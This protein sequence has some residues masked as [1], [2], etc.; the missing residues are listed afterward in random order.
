MKRLLLPVVL[1]FILLAVPSA[2]RADYYFLVD[3]NGANEAPPNNETGTGAAVVI[4]NDALTKI[5][6]RASFSG[7]TGPAIAA[8]FHVGDVGVAGPV[9]LPF[10]NFP[11][12]DSDP[13]YKITL[14]A[15]DFQPGGGL[16]TFDDAI[17]AF[18]AGRMYMNIH[19]AAHPGGEIRGQVYYYGP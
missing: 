9:V 10:S 2:A 14:K 19:T 3:L 12:V 4:I 6:V 11:A 16:Q 1:A 5:K 8:H 13:K 7:L 18:F 15:A 17:N